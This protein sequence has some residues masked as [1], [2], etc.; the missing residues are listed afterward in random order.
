MSSSLETLL[1]EADSLARSSLLPA[2]PDFAVPEEYALLASGVSPHLTLTEAPGMGKG[3]MAAS[4]VPRGT[5]LMVAKPMALVMDWQDDTPSINDEEMEDEDEEEKEP[6][7][8]ELLLLQILDLLHE[9]PDL[10]TER[11]STLFPRDDD[12]P[13]LPAW[14]CQDDDV[15]FQIEGKVEKLRSNRLLE[16]H[17]AQI[18]KRLPLIIRHNVLSVETCPELL[19]YPGPNG[20]SIL[21]GVGLYHWPS[22]FNHSRRPNCSRWAVGDIMFFYANQDIEIGSQVC[23]SYIEHDVLC[24]SAWRRNGLLRMNFDDADY[25]A[26]ES[27]EPSPEEAEGPDQPVMDSAVQ[28]EL[29][30]MDPFERLK[31]IEELTQQAMGTKDPSGGRVGAPESSV[32]SKWFLCDIHNLRILK[33]ITLEGMGQSAEALKLWEECVK[34]VEEKLPPCDE[35]SVVMRVQAALSAFRNGD[36]TRAKQHADA[37]LETHAMVFGGGVARF[38]RRYRHDLELEFRSNNKSS[39]PRGSTGTVDALWP[40]T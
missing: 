27:S 28:T 26:M 21:S 32:A 1:D 10:W 34:F 5:L 36:V 6:R 22:F 33:A 37:A 24:E 14:V 19:S 3:W 13:N 2:R 23:I 38:R 31:A 16:P 8:N 29:M 18:A 39:D 9:Q 15:F 7:V 35:A 17:A 25:E 11:L 4:D 30:G 20:H 12:L 40:P